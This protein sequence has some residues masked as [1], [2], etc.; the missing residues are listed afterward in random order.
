MWYTLLLATVPL[1][2]I[3]SS[4]NFTKFHKQLAAKRWQVLES[5][6]FERDWLHVLS[7]V[8]PW[9]HMIEV[10]FQ[11]SLLNSEQVLSNEPTDRKFHIDVPVEINRVLWANQLKNFENKVPAFCT[12]CRS[13]VQ[14]IVDQIMQQG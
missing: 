3:E 11:A 2:Y 10:V 1:I 7:A 6:A 14:A 13:V 5:F 8:K 12:L 4:K 9:N